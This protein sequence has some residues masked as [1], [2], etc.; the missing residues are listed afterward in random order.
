MYCIEI[1]LQ[2]L[3][4]LKTQFVVFENSLNTPGI[5]FTNSS[6]NPVQWDS[7]LWPLQ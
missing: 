5:L 7:N 2:T 1:F 3:L 4:E 6:M